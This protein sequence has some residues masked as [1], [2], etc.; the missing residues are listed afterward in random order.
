[1]SRLAKG[2][3]AAS[4]S[5]GEAGPDISSVFSTWLYRGT[6]ASQTI[7]TG[8]DLATDGGMIFIKNRDANAESAVF[9]TENGVNRYASTVSV[10]PFQNIGG[11]LTQFGSNGFSISSST[12]DGLINNANVAYASWSFKRHEK[13]FDVVEYTGD[14]NSSQQI[15]HN[16][17]SVPGAIIIKK[18]AGAISGNGPWI[19]YHKQIG[20]TQ[21]MQIQTVDNPITDSTVFNNTA[22]TSTHFTVGSTND[23]NGTNNTYIAYIFADNNGDGIFGPN[24][25]QDI[26]KCGSFGGSGGSQ[27]VN[28]GW[29]PQFVLMKIYSGTDTGSRGTRWIVTDSMRG[30]AP[31]LADT[32]G[33]A[34]W[35]DSGNSEDED[36][37][38]NVTPTGFQ[39]QNSS[40]APS[41]VYIAIRRGPLFQPET[42]D[43]VY[44]N[45]ALT[46]TAGDKYTGPTVPLF[47]VDMAIST[48]P[49][50]GQT[51]DLF[52]RSQQF[53]YTQPSGAAGPI[54][55]LNYNRVL[56]DSNQEFKSD[57]F[58]PSVTNPMRF[59]EFKRAPGFFDIAAYTGNG[60]STTS[61]QYVPHNLGVVP[62][63]FWVKSVTIGVT[64]HWKVYHKDLSGST[65]PDAADNYLELDTDIRA[66][67][68][69][70]NW[71]STA[72]TSTNFRVGGN[73]NDV[74]LNNRK[75]LAYLFATL[76]GISKVGSFSHTL[77]STT[78]VDCG[79]SSGS[80]FVLVKRWDV[81]GVD[82]WLWDSQRGIGAGNDPIIL[83]NTTQA[84]QTN[85][86]YINTLSSGFQMT[87]TLPTGEYIFY[88][89]AN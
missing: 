48:I 47:P 10:L 3:R 67:E 4:A 66:L 63:M 41:Y 5:A 70:N 22:P 2:L 42:V 64:A 32:R 33:R 44:H 87:T 84:Q 58:S 49:N 85:A 50:L 13:F 72:P 77:G 1:M 55:S 46:S 34:I 43:E 61:R 62:E 78:D 82:W 86:D 51:K 7:P 15:P 40:E 31:T 16:L 28:L 6:N 54:T 80:R 89:I 71:G 24:A 76:P 26:I 65:Y 38:L 12:I 30:T 25:D 81:Q 52:T 60:T 21:Y 14:G 19:F 73:H 23:V 39:W 57:Q 35:L 11:S 75:Y 79:F 88:A 36:Q 69:V 68:D 83:L 9:D 27:T 59:W 56:F 53:I 17:G 37:Y 74:N 18:T 20:P 8:V 29:E 45:Q